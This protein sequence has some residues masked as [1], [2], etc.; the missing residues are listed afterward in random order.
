MQL[1][2]NAQVERLTFARRTAD[3]R[4]NPVFAAM[5][6]MKPGQHLLVE[7]RDWKSKVTIA[8]YVSNAFNNSGARF[9]TKSLA[10][11]TGWVVTRVS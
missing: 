1:L 9:T 4:Q 3:S 10:D 11:G 8:R 2:S 5:R 6:N 7:K